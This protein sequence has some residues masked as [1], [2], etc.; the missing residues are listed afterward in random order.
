MSKRYGY[1]IERIIERSN[2]DRAFDEVVDKLPEPKVIYLRDG[3]I[4]R[5]RKNQKSRREYYRERREEIIKRLTEKIKNGTFRVRGYIEMEVHDGPKDRIVQSPCVEDRIGCNSIMRIVED[6]LYP[7]VIKTSAASI[8]GRGMHK[9]FCKMRRDIMNDPE[10]TRFFYKCDIRKFFESIDQELMWKCIQS[11]IKDPVL[12]PILHNF[13]MLME[14]GLSIGLR[15]SQCY[16]NMFLSFVDHFIKDYLGI[17]YYYRYCDDIVILAG[18]KTELWLLRDTIHEQVGLAK[19]EIKPNEAIKPITEG[20]DFLGFVYDGK[21]ARLRKRTKQKAARKLSYLK[22]RKRKQEIAGSLKGMAQWGD[23]KHLYKTLTGK[24]MTDIGEVEIAITYSD[25]KKRFKGA[26]IKPRELEKRPFVVVDFERDVIPRWDIDRYERELKE[27][28]GDTSRVVPTKAKYVASIIFEGKPRKIWTGLEEN[29]V[30]L[31]KMAELGNF[32][33]FSSIEV[34]YCGKFP[35][36]TFCSAVSLGFTPP[37]DDEVENIVKQ[38]NM[39][40]YKNE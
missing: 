26:E 25:G 35:R 19:L 40:I 34:D 10:G 21:K 16:G 33:F 36:Y 5:P 9:L 39:S 17:K 13:I 4:K 24:N 22:S 23:C 31:E 8:P 2:M 29:K 11:K 38:Y 30:R 27:A 6:V 7:S 14:H 3:R 37:S 28:C 20:I 15:S 32:P 1:L 12:L 18:T